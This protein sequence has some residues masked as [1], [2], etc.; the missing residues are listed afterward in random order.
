[1]N[2]IYYP[3]YLVRTG[4]GTYLFEAM[5]GNNIYMEKNV[6]KQSKVGLPPNVVKVLELFRQRSQ[7]NLEMIIEGS[8][9]GFS[10]VEDTLEMMKS[11]MLVREDVKDGEKIYSRTMLNMAVKPFR[12][13]PVS[14]VIDGKVMKA[15]ISED[16]LKKN[17]CGLLP[18][19]KSI[20]YVYYPYYI[21]KDFM[22]DGLTGRKKEIKKGRK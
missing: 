1:M 2:T 17:V 3:C 9:L 15:K 6:V 12:S 21:G 18:N 5:N 13:E 22:I 14:S 16:A 11:L 7:M 20:E 19:I 4:K 8:G 10:G